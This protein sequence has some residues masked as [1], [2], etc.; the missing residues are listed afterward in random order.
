MNKVR[1][2]LMDICKT[3]LF[4][5]GAGLSLMILSSLIALVFTGALVPALQAGKSFLLITGALILFVAAIGF[6]KREGFYL[7]DTNK[8]KF[9][10]KHLSLHWALFL[11]GFAL[12]L[13]GGSI[14]YFL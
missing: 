12:A 10:L 9:P 6:F 4:A 11:L 1:F 8:S 5:L 14:D 2:I 7:S 3:L 13:I